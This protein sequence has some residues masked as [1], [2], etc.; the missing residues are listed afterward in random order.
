MP[1]FGFFAVAFGDGDKTPDTHHVKHQTPGPIVHHTRDPKP[2]S[3]HEVR[4]PNVD[5]VRDPKPYS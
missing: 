5:R 4:N 1:G 2:Y 3:A